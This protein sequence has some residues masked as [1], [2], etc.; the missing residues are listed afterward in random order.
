VSEFLLRPGFNFIL[1]SSKTTR[2]EMFSAEHGSRR[3]V[4]HICMVITDGASRYPRQ[5]AV[6][7]SLLRQA[8]IDVFAIGKA[9]RKTSLLK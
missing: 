2:N 9:G 1:F 3:D 7:A 6:E 4:A 8:G 5:T